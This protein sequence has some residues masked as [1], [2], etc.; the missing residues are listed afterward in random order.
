MRRAGVLSVARERQ[1]EEGQDTGLTLRQNTVRTETTPNQEMR[2]LARDWDK[3]PTDNY[4]VTIIIIIKDY[5]HIYTL[6]QP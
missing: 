4:Y 2:N 1:R 3:S 5:F 6:E